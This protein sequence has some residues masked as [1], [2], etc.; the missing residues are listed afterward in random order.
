MCMVLL[1][2]LSDNLNYLYADFSSYADSLEAHEWVSIVP[3]EIFTSPCS[4]LRTF[5]IPFQESTQAY[6]YCPH[7]KPKILYQSLHQ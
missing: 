6:N 2:I 4:Y 3:A 1:W 7:L 5:N